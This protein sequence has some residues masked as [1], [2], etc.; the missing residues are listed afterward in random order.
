MISQT[1]CSLGGCWSRR[2]L[3]R[4]MPSFWKGLRSIS[5]PAFIE[6][7]SLNIEHSA[8]TDPQAR[9]AGE[10]VRHD[11][12]PHERNRN[13]SI[14]LHER[15]GPLPTADIAR[16]LRPREQRISRPAL[17]ESPHRH[18][19]QTNSSE[20]LPGALASLLCLG[21]G[22]EG[23]RAS[24]HPRDAEVLP[25]RRVI[26]LRA[27]APGRQPRDAHAARPRSSPHEIATDGRN[28]R[29]RRPTSPTASPQRP[30]GQPSPG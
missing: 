26:H 30:S 2:P 16:L 25:A 10:P 6:A 12:I 19:P 4:E 8:C 1:C 24:Q 21:L 20:P 11:L 9:A 15:L 14:A 5:L 17:P 23:P 13:L 28:R 22:L 27:P 3:P 18:V 7:A 29:V